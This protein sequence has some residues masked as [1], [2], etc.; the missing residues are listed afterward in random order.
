VNDPASFLYLVRY[1]EEGK[2]QP[3]P[4]QLFDIVT[5]Q[6]G[7]QIQAELKIPGFPADKPITRLFEIGF[8]VDLAANGVNTYL[9]YYGVPA[10][11]V[12]PAAPAAPLQYT[13]ANPGVSIDTG[14]V[15]FHLNPKSGSMLYF[16][17]KF[18]A[19]KKDY[20]FA[21]TEKRDVH[22][23]P[24]VYTPQMSWGHTSDWDMGMP[25]PYTPSLRVVQGP[26]AYRS[27]RAGLIPRSNETKTTVSY[28][29]F[30]GAPFFYTSSS[31]EFT[32]DTQ[33]YS[34]RNSEYVFSRG[35]MTRAVWADAQ[36]NPQET[37]LYDADNPRRILGKVAVLPSDVPYLGMFNER[38][39]IGLCV[40]TQAYYAASH[41]LAGD[42]ANLW[43]QFYISDPGLWVN[44]PD[45]GNYA[46]AYL[47]R[48]EIY[49][50]TV[51]PKDTIFAERNAVVVFKVGQGEHRFDDMLRW[52][53]LIRTPPQVSVSPVG[54]SP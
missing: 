30:A 33:V 27:F 7:A 31:M 8:P 26:Y 29:F 45:R 18:S 15:I 35:V 44:T 52:V 54:A 5:P 24:D 53:K 13:G 12:T 34:V 40:V 22:Y 41:S 38:D 39:G 48:P 21:Q 4:F 16:T 14:E 23:N 25:G 19:G 43:S 32:L 46:F 49:H 51:V 9:L 42:A 1:D 11:P 37:L 6:A 28:T 20:S 10:A 17:P 47:V 36:G 3:V 2:N 50:L